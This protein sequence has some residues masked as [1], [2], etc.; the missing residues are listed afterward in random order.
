V[1][2][3][4]SAESMILISAPPAE[5]MILLVHAES[6]ILSA[7]SAKQQSTISCSRKCGNNSSGRGNSGSGDGFDDGSSNNGYSDDSN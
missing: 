7:G 2:C 6:I 4:E 1:G 3:A 5:R